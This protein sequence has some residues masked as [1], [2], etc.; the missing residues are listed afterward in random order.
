MSRNSIMRRQG[1]KKVLRLERQSIKECERKKDK[2]TLADK[3]TVAPTVT[4]P[5]YAT[6][7]DTHR[8]LH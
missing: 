1:R 8:L 6:M 4:A 7:K 2:H 3:K 5:L